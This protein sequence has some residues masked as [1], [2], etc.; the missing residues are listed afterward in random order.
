MGAAEAAK[1]DHD[2][3]VVD[4]CDDSDGDDDDHDGVHGKEGR[5]AAA[6]A[7]APTAPPRHKRRP[8]R[9]APPLVHHHDEDRVID[10]VASGGALS[11]PAR[12]TANADN[13]NDAYWNALGPLRFAFC[14]TLRHH[15]F[16]AAASAGHAVPTTRHS[17]HPRTTSS[18]S[19]TTA[20][21][22][23]LYRELLAYQLN[24]PVNVQSSIFVRAQESRVD[25]VRALITGALWV[26]VVV[27]RLADVGGG[28][29]LE[30][31]RDQG[32]HSSRRVSLIRVDLN[33][34]LFF[35]RVLPY[36][37]HPPPHIQVRT[38]LRTP[39]DVL[40][41]TLP[42]TIIPTDLRKFSS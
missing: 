32:P 19:S 36:S 11:A 4:L 16:A 21:T 22:T 1:I 39:W 15:A 40:S 17:R 33:L 6:E 7:A 9:S 42:C 29:F 28:C 34:S 13:D 14:A 31:R 23:S 20:N 5:T 3:V 38:T 18:A 26:V 24:L 30:G 2:V 8:K 35:T 27:D 10:L 37:F 12:G 41:L 25:L